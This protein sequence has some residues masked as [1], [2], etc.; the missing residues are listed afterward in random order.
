M[1][2]ILF[3]F[4]A[5]ALALQA[6]PQKSNA[7]K[8]PAEAKNIFAQV[9]PETQAT[10]EKKDGNY[11]VNVTEAGK[12]I[13]SVTDINET[14]LETETD[15]PVPELAPDAAAYLKQHDK[16]VKIKEPSK[17]VKLNGEINYEVLVNKWSLNFDA[18]DRFSGVEND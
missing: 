7:D 4:L 9:S 1:R 3:T 11:E 17:M 13:S 12:T 16:N 10:G 18:N 14:I 15:V 8:S 5:V 2:I 6:S